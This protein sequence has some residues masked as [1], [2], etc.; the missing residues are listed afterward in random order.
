M[1]RVPTPFVL[2]MQFFTWE[3]NRLSFLP[4]DTIPLH[5]PLRTPGAYWC[6]FVQKSIAIIK[7]GFGVLCHGFCKHCVVATEV[8][9]QWINRRMVLKMLSRLEEGVDVFGSYFNISYL[10]LIKTPEESIKKS[11]YKSWKI[12]RF[13]FLT[14]FGQ[15]RQ[16]LW[17]RER[18]SFGYR[19]KTRSG[20]TITFSVKLLRICGNKMPTRCSRG[21][22]C[23]CY[24]LL[25]MFRAPICP[26]SGAQE[27]YTV[28]AAYGISCCGFQVAGLVWSWGL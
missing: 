4:S 27:Y 22:Y 15:R 14:L 3:I 9:E 21:F 13:S 18:G 1:V 17:P 24:C 10:H 28:V 2:F 11:Y 19:K 5:F 23:R 26:S 25:N 7:R 6:P 20:L 8:V 16:C 12:Y